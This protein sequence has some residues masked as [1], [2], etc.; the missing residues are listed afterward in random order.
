MMQQ[1]CWE[2]RLGVVLLAALCLS[3][4]QGCLSFVHPLDLPTKEQ[5]A[6]G[7]VNPAPCR[8]HVHIFLLHGL[9]PFDLANLY[10]LTEYIQQLGYIK[11]HYGQCFH[12]WEF[13]KEICRIHKQDPQARFVL[14]GF[15]LGTNIA[16]EVAHAVKEDG[17]VI[18][19]LIYLGGGY[20]LPNTPRAQPKN[21]VRI[22]N[23][24]AEGCAEKKMLDRAENVYYDDVW[25]FGSPTHPQT[26]ELLARELV[27][28]AARVPYVE[29][30][31]P[32]PPEMEN[33]VPMPRRLTPAEDRQKS[34]QLPP[35]W[36][37]LESRTATG[38][39]RPPRLAQP[40]ENPDA[41]R[42]PFAVNP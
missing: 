8:N 25:H 36:K 18:D 35:E 22:V 32:L 40:T 12:L 23:I 21:V 6:C 14:I 19:L 41:R 13:K 34:S 33:E 20:T 2:R 10:G 5:I 38:E 11:T 31:P 42:I 3:G 26:R 1:G 4:G 17:V 15:S 39:L 16:R 27:A 29:Q 37:F 7:E 28:V 24:L 30:S 9:D